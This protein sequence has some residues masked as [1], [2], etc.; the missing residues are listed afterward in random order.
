[1]ID[2][3]YKIASLVKKCRKKLFKFPMIY[4]AEQVALHVIFRLALVSFL[5]FF[6]IHIMSGTC[7]ISF[8]DKSAIVALWSSTDQR[9]NNVW[10]RTENVHTQGVEKDH[11]II[12]K[13]TLQNHAKANEGSSQCPKDHT[14]YSIY[15]LPRICILYWINWLSLKKVTNFWSR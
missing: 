1:M 5:N 3:R 14:N 11:A 10:S 7:Q 13:L 4:F 8:V 2:K 15:I 6:V 12:P 9:G